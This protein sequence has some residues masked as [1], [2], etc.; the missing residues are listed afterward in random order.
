VP[1]FGVL[2]LIGSLG[3]GVLLALE[4]R[5]VVVQARVG[6]VVW[7]GHL[8]TALI[9]GA[10]LACWFMLGV[11]FIRCRLAERRRRAASRSAA[12]SRPPAQRLAH[13]SPRRLGAGRSISATKAPTAPPRTNA[14]RSTVPS[15]APST[16][17]TTQRGADQRGR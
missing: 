13:L 9:V 14:Y 2:L 7:T 5:D 17:L 6:H 16:A 12:R 11:A 10:L 4:N 8:Y 3:G 1:I 15:T